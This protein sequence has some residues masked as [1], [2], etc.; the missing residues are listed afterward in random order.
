MPEN[1][2]CGL[3]SEDRRLTDSS[4]GPFCAI[5]LA[6]SIFVLGVNSNYLDTH[7]THVFYAGAVTLSV[8]YDLL[9]KQA[10]A[11]VHVTHLSSFLCLKILYLRH[12]T[13]CILYFLQ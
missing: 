2:G 9:E 1:I 13:C 12:A 6:F 7:Y 8:I 4:M 5:S 3:R 11:F 10:F